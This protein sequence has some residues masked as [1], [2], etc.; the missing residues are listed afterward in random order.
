MKMWHSY[1]AF[2]RI[3][4]EIADNKIKQTKKKKKKKKTRIW[5][6]FKNRS[7]LIVNVGDNSI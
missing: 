4:L 2:R 6:K 7:G 1:S 5:R 3:L